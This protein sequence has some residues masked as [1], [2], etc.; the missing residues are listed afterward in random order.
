MQKKLTRYKSRF[1][2]TLMM[3]SFFV[4]IRAFEDNLFYDPFLSY[5]KSDF[6]SLPLPAFDSFRLF[7]G[8]LFRYSLNTVISLGLIYVLFRDIMMVKFTSL[9]FVFFFL[10]L[11]S[12]FYLLIYFFGA[13]NNLMLFY[14]RRFLIQPI[15][16]LVFIPAFYFQT[17]MK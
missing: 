8:L 14:I 3:V 5:F 13:D 6:N 2:V 10:I 16:V 1:L 17:R 7:L 15:L 11:V 9:L 12:A 4:L